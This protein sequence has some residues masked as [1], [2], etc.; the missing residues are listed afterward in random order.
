MTRSWDNY[1]L[2]AV[3]DGIVS[4][5]SGAVGFVVA[6]VAG[7]VIGF[8][9]YGVTLE[10][11]QDGFFI[12]YMLTMFP[13]RFLQHL[14][15]ATGIIIALAFITLTAAFFVT[16]RFKAECLLGLCLSIGL[17]VFQAIG[18]VEEPGSDAWLRFAEISIGIVGIFILVKLIAGMAACKREK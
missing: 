6:I 3:L 4:A 18:L 14:L 5:F 16:E 7:V 15:D 13:V 1:P 17:Y 11:T 10:E 8:T 9:S 2:S 12:I